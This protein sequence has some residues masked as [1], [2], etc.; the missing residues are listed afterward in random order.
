MSIIYSSLCVGVVTFMELV[1]NDLECILFD[2]FRVS[3]VTCYDP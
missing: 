1:F 3:N 2:F